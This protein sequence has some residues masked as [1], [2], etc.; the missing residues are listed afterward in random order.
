MHACTIGG[1]N[2]EANA[3][4]KVPIVQPNIGVVIK[5]PKN[6]NFTS[7]FSNA[8]KAKTSSV[9]Q[10]AMIQ[11]FISGVFGSIFC[12]S[13]NDIKKYLRLMTNVVS[14][15]SIYGAPPSMSCM[16]ANWPAEAMLV[17]EIKV[18]SIGLKPIFTAISPNVND[19]GMY[20][21]QMGKPFFIP[22]KYSFMQ[23]YIKR[24][25]TTDSRPV[26]LP[27]LNKNF[28]RCIIILF[29][30]SCLS[31]SVSFQQLILNVGRHLAIFVEFQ[32][33]RCSSGC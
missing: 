7:C 23:G 21:K 16:P 13:D 26:V 24:S 28:V 22:L 4:R 25:N 9:I 14:T 29:V 18:A 30:F 15:I 2:P 6:E 8:A 32:R 20:P 12:D 31:F 1:S 5:P 11:R 27:E 10:K 3:P 19:T 33:I 17:I